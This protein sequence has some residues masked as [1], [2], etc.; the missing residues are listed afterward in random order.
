MPCRP[1][2]QYTSTPLSHT[3]GA[4]WPAWKPPTSPA[5]R[6]TNPSHP[7]PT[8]RC[9]PLP[10]LEMLR[11]SGGP[12]HPG[13]PTPLVRPLPS[14][15]DFAATYKLVVDDF[16]LRYLATDVIT[17][18]LN[19]A[20]HGDFSMLARCGIPLSALLRSKPVVR[21][22]N[23]PMLS[24]RS[25]VRLVGPPGN[26][27][28]GPVGPLFQAHQPSFL[29]WQVRA[30]LAR[31]EMSLA[32]GVPHFQ[33]HQP[34]FLSWPQVRTRLWP[35]WTT[36]GPYLLRLD[37]RGGPFIQ[38]RQSIP[39]SQSP[40]PYPPHPPLAHPPPP[41]TTHPLGRTSPHAQSPR[42]QVRRQSP[43]AGALSVVVAHNGST[44]PLN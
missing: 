12:S 14:Q 5:S 37:D 2:H 31:L 35:A 42:S 8:R 16:L 30:P 26:A 43:R 44:Y 24:V 17:L 32:Y 6:H 22:V 7:S 15:W 11:V 13:T 27:V 36:V 28:S 19:M 4:R 23:H 20:S 9:A 18:E 1:S 38:R 41:P 40:L 34:S 3:P 21:L 10:R 29:S 33:A 39:P 25:Q